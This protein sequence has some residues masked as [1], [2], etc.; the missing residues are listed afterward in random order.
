MGGQDGF[1]LKFDPK[2]AGSGGI[3]YS[4]YIASLGLQTAYG[5][6]VDS[7]GIIWV[8]GWTNDTIFDPN[9][10]PKTTPSQDIDGFLMGISPQ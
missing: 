2:V 5:V 6:D 10:T 4:S 7:N 1:V 9:V 3:M 8:T